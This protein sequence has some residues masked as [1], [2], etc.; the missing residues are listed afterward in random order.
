LESKYSSQTLITVHPSAI[1]RLR[2]KDERE[3]AFNDL[4]ND[5]RFLT[6][7]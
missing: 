7:R 2:E 3:K 4:V 1:L 5:L 6:G